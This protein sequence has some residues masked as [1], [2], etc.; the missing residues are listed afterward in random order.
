MDRRILN[1]YPFLL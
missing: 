1:I